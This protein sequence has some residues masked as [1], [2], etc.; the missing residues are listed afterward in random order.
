MRKIDAD[1]KLIFYAGDSAILF[2][3]KD[4]KGI[5]QKLRK[6]MESCSEWLIDN[7][8]SLHLGITE[9]VRFSSQL[10]KEHFTYLY[11][12]YFYK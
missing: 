6:V 7:K 11:F 4:P 1:C 10:E 2:A 9:C 12:T 8:L 3:H 5:S